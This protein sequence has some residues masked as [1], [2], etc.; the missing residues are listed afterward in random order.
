MTVLGQAGELAGVVSASDLATK[1]GTTVI[2]VMSP[3]VIAVN[4]KMG[5]YSAYN[6]LMSTGLAK[7]PVVE[8]QAG[9]R[10]FKGWITHHDINKA[11]GLG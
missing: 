8:E 1:T 10:I 9:K 4:T 7:L 5:L 3:Q 6:L 11:M 2:D